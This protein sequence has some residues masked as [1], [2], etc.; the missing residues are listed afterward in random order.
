[1]VIKFDVPLGSFP[2]S[3]PQP[4]A[5]PGQQASRRARRSSMR[6]SYAFWASSIVPCLSVADTNFAI[7][8]LLDSTEEVSV[9]RSVVNLSIFPVIIFVFSPIRF[10]KNSAVSG[11]PGA[12]FPS[13]GAAEAA[14]ING[15]P[16]AISMTSPW[17][18]AVPAVAAP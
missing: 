14:P 6:A 12:W 2:V 1:M 3:G 9:M 18:G 8:A 15:W 11:S 5:K 16:P 4:G 7:S 13:T 17:I 10:L